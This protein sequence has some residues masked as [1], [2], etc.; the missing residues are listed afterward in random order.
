M[1]SNLLQVGPSAGERL[2]AVAD[3]PQLPSI[4]LEMIDAVLG[5]GGLTAIAAIA[6][7]YV[8]APVAV[9]VPSLGPA[10]PESEPLHRY[11]GGVLAGAEPT[12]PVG[13]TREVPIVARGERVGSALLLGLGVAG[14][15]AVL[16][17]AA[18]A[19]LAELAAA[20]ARDEAEQRLH[21]SFIKEV[22]ER[23]DLSSEDVL[24]R[25]ARL[26]CDLGEGVVGL[27]AELAS[28]VPSRLTATI[29]G[30]CPGAIAQPI[31]GRLYALLP[32]S[33]ERARALAAR[34]ERLAPI[35]V[36][37]HYRD[38]ADAGRALDEAELVLGVAA[39]GGSSPVEQIGD[40]TYRLLFRIL[41]NHPEEMRILFEDTVAPL[42]RYDAQYETDLL[43]TVSEY[44]HGQNCNMN[45]T[46]QAIRTHRH[47]VSYRL[48]R[49][50]ELTGLDPFTSD[51]RERLGLGL[52]ALRIV[53]PTS[54]RPA[55]DPER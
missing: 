20:A 54:L 51:D 41:A 33:I 43:A 29:A 6:G 16:H 12:P 15:T 50:R 23:N 3:P 45:A 7:G 26:G 13:I 2:S 8:G 48:E 25:A 35:G 30:E 9:V 49:V 52:K 47:T 46:A 17:L 27:C 31:E 14:S 55:G 19:T 44:L 36:S 4:L 32:C 24:R 53:D 38:A 22:M 34:L 40:S 39:A 10:E 42:V 1:P 37:T 11:V 21:G 18:T 28:T 5:G